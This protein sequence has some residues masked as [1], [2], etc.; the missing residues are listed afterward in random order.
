MRWGWTHTWNEPIR[1]AEVV[2]DTV[3]QEGVSVWLYLRLTR[4]QLPVNMVAGISWGFLIHQTDRIGFKKPSTQLLCCYIRPWL[5]FDIW[6]FVGGKVTMRVFVT[7]HFPRDSSPI[8][9]CQGAFTPFGLSVSDG[10]PDAARLDS[11]AR[12]WGCYLKCPY[13]TDPKHTATTF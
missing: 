8:L 10:I 6:I 1:Q 4:M 7:V 9:S 3:H 13:T 5:T 11:P 12:R 2:Y